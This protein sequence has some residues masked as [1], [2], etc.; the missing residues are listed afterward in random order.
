MVD[1]EYPRHPLF[2]RD[3][4][5]P[6]D[7][8][9]HYVTFR[10]QR[11]QDDAEAFCPEDFP[12]REVRSWAQ[13]VTWWGG[14]RYKAIGK[15][16]KH[17]V[18]AYCP[19]GAEWLPFDTDSRPF[20]LRNGSPYA[21]TAP[22]PAP[23]VPPA[24]ALPSPSAPSG[25]E[26]LAT[27][28]AKLVERLDVFM[29]VPVP[30]PA[31]ENDDSWLVMA[32]INSQ[33]QTTQ[34]T[35]NALASD[36]KVQHLMLQVFK[37]LRPAPAPPPQGVAEIPSDAEGREGV[38]MRP[39]PAGEP[40]ANPSQTGV[41]TVSREAE[42]KQIVSVYEDGDVP[43]GREGGGARRRA[44]TAPAARGAPVCRHHGRRRRR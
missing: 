22:E 38:A 42:A 30:A 23:A 3:D 15:D 37:E 32:L 4:D 11:S 29:A 41:S 26:L 5:M 7:R 20:T 12:A 14:G 17:R 40:F 43:S 13:V 10:R 31:A 8:D 25:L 33:T 21:R 1:A 19:A 6:E 36:N 28:L 24:A 2:P 16:A 35:F 34:A 9:I 27:N 39:S 18:I 44:G